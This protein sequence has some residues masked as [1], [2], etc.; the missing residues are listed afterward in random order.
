MIYVECKADVALVE[1]ITEVPEDIIHAGCKSEVCKQLKRER[2]CM[3]M[4]DEDP[5]GSQPL[6]MNIMEQEDNLPQY[7]IKTLHDDDNNNNLIVLCP[8]LEDW[9]LKNAV[10]ADI[11]VTE[12][13]L[14][15]HAIGLHRIINR[16]LDEFKRLVANL[17]GHGRMEVLERLLK[18]KNE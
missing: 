18:S 2:D 16:R 10:E 17:K 6:Y 4:V 14:P 5:W 15:N 8:K 7:E 9:V 11:D 3:G 13:G 1:L 12:Y